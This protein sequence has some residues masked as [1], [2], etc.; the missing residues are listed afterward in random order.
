MK[1]ILVVCHDRSLRLTRMSLLE[2]AGYRVESVARD[3]EAIARLEVEQFDL[4]LIGRSSSLP[5]R[6]KDQRLRE[7]YPDLLIVRIDRVDR[8]QSTPALRTADPHPRLTLNA[9]LGECPQ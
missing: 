1:G 6:I 9:M 4:V 8:G 7:K 3:H 5:Q 2:A